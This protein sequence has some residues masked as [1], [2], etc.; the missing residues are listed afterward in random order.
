M[1]KNI[2]PLLGDDDTMFYNG[3]GTPPMGGVISSKN[4]EEL[5][6]KNGCRMLEGPVT[7]ALRRALLELRQKETKK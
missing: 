5:L 4:I 6:T 1:I 3:S 2:R 7:K